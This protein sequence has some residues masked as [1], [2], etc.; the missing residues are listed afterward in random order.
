ML[1]HPD[2]SG[3]EDHPSPADALEVVGHFEVA[4]GGLLREDV[5]EERPELRDVPL[6]VT[7]FVEESPRSLLGCDAEAG[8]ERAIGLPD[9]E[10]VVEDEERRADGIDDGLRDDAGGERIQVVALGFAHGHSTA[11]PGREPVPPLVVEWA[12]ARL[13]DV[14]PRRLFVPYLDWPSPNNPAWSPAIQS[15]GPTQCR[16]PR[17]APWSS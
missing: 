16:P 2:F 3:V 7:Q 9:A 12:A 5:F 6:A 8:V 17:A 14:P 1:R 4:E 11:L 10:F 13:G 15:T